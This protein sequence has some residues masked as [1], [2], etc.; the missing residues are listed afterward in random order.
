VKL[1]RRVAVVDSPQLGFNWSEAIQEKTTK[2]F[3]NLTKPLQFKKRKQKISTYIHIC[4]MIK[5]NKTNLKEI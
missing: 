1:L 5:I 2:Y 3:E 4:V